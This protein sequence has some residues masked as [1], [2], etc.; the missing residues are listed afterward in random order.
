MAVLTTIK[1]RSLRIK[2]QKG[3]KVTSKTHGPL[4]EDVANEAIMETAKA[5]LSV[6][7]YPSAGVEV[8]TVMDLKE[9][10]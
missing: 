5:I 3:D 4:G 9:S 7:A 8:V 2:N 1:S 6:M 10:V